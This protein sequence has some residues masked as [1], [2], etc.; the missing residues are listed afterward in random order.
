MRIKASFR[1]A[2]T[3]WALASAVAAS[4]SAVCCSDAGTP[5]GGEPEA[6]ITTDAQLFMLITATHPYAGYALFPG[7]DSVVSGTLNG[8]GAHQPLV[9]VSMNPIALASLAADTLTAGS[10]FAQGSIIVKEIREQGATTLLAVMMKEPAS[11]DAA[12]GWLWAEFT[13]E[14]T[15]VFS[16][17]NRGDGCVP[18]HSREQGLRNDLVRTFE[19]RVP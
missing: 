12:G 7:V 13:P 10:A 17:K 2:G 9:R 8:S 18:C 6:V 14:G 4:L 3:S 19:R 1:T 5:P 11:D 15:A 16:L